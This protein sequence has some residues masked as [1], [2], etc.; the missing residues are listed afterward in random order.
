MINNTS[1]HNQINEWIQ[2]NKNEV[3]RLTQKLVRIPSVSGLEYEVQRYIHKI[4]EGMDLK[5]DMVFPEVKRLRENPDFFE[6]TSFLKYGYDNRPNVSGTVRGSGGGRSL[7]LSGHIDV[8]SP[9]PI[10]RWTRDPWSGEILDKTVHGRGSGDMK[11]G[12]AA[13]IFAVRALQETGIRLKGDIQIETTIEEEDGGV[14]GALYMRTVKPA[15]DAALIP[16]PTDLNV[17]VASAG[18]MYFRVTVLGVPA[19]AATAH[20]GMNAILKT[21]PIIQAIDT[22]NKSRQARISYSFVE[23]DSS[24]RGKV[25]TINIGVIRAGDWPSTVPGSCLIE[26]RIGWP[27][28]ESREDIVKQVENAI[29]TA[30]QSDEWLRDNPPVVEWFGWRARPHE[31]SPNDEFI[32]TI[33]KEVITVSGRVPTFTGGSAGLDTRH[34]VHHGIPA[35]TFGPKAERIHSFD[36]VVHIDSI[37]QVAQVIAS[38]MVD[39]CCVIE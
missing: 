22:L 32:Q 4:L 18:V 12:V 23:S 31:L 21:I 35:A 11:A 15:T 6:T 17:T 24:M 36:E 27:P 19:H 16:E 8:V 14:G 38:T 34:F 1:V 13:M 10:K 28:G 39:W 33:R 29:K 3:I 7:T 30:A 25:T 5:P 37:V 20:I 2:G 9:E 26:C